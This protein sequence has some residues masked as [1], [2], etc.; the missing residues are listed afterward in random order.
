[1]SRSETLEKA[2]Q[3]IVKEEIEKFKHEQSTEQKAVNKLIAFRTNRVPTV[4]QNNIFGKKS[5]GARK[6]TGEIY[7]SSA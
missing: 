3:E 2:I 5:R 6:A 7:K 4:P 1:M